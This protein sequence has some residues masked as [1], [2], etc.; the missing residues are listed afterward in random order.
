MKAKVNLQTV[1]KQ[2]KENT[3]L[4]QVA[5]IFPTIQGEGPYAGQAA[6]FIRLAGCNLQC[7]ACDTDYTSTRR[8]MKVDE[9]VS[10]AYEYWR[11]RHGMRLVVIT[12]GE[13][14][15]QPCG[16][17][18]TNLREQGF[19]IQFETNGTLYDPS[20]S[21][22]DYRHLSIVCS[23]KT[24]AINGLLS[25]RITAYKYVVRAGEIDPYDGLPLSTMGVD[26]EHPGMTPARP[27]LG[28]SPDKVYIQP[29]D[30]QDEYSNR[31][32]VAAA[33]EV[34]KKHGYILSIQTHKII[35]LP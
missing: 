17:L 28:W 32:N 11:E 26:F 25:K 31:A 14:F 1:E 6:I 10:V 30:E 12:G 15:R 20:I 3:G 21:E 18:V 9:V 5:E 7:P 8:V 34:V 33:V 23:P 35:G 13:P 19:R 4:L 22:D 16:W 2:E 27:P 29:Q 24:P